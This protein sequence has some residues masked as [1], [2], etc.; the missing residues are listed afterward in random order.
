DEVIA[1]EEV[2]GVFRIGRL[3]PEPRKGSEGGARPLPSVADQIVDAPGAPPVGMAA[4]RRRVPAHEV[5]NTVA[6]GVRRGLAPRERALLSPGHTVRRALKLRLGRKPGAA[7]ARV[8]L[9]L[10]VAD[11]D[12]PGRRKG[13][14]LEQAAPTPASLLV[15]PERR[16]PK[17]S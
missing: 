2:G 3:W 9:R 15:L 6:A 10:G 17:V 13:D 1:V 14:R 8:G 4:G 12:R 5:E 11:V 7:P 16:M